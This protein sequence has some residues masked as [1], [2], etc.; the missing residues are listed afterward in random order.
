MENKQ[1]TVS[2]WISL[3]TNIEQ[4][5]QKISESMDNEK[6]TIEIKPYAPKRK[7][8]IIYECQIKLVETMLSSTHEELEQEEGTHSDSDV[9][10]DELEGEQA[11]SE[12]PN[13]GD[14]D[15]VYQNTITLETLDSDSHSDL[16]SLCENHGSTNSTT[17]MNTL[18]EGKLATEK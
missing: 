10:T 6:I 3:I 2:K 8:E 15:N 13:S 1:D 7:T 4:E 5:A 17:N 12:S 11:S 9:S 16:E 18:K 14:D